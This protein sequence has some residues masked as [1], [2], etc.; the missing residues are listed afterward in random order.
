MSR[1]SIRDLRNHG[2]DVVDRVA[3]GERVVVTRGGR[4]VAELRPAAKCGL[5]AAVLLERWR[6]LPPVD[7]AG[8]R[9]DIEGLLDTSTVILLTRISDP[10]ALPETPL[11]SAITLAELA[12][13]PLVARDEPERRRRSRGC[14]GTVVAMQRRSPSEPPERLTPPAR[15]SHHTGT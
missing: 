5:A 7:P 9:S 10:T 6:R 12:V 1:V 13:G 15:R 2:G 4:A 8:L 14:G 11:M 3:A